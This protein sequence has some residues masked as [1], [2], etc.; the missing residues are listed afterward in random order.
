MYP[1][2]RPSKW[3]PSLLTFIAIVQL[4]NALFSLVWAGV[5]GVSL[6]MF[7]FL[8]IFVFAYFSWKWYLDEKNTHE[9]NAA[10]W[11]AEHAR[12]EA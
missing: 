11:E 9:A 8:L 7:G 4:G 3:L 6:S 10:T 2:K 5:L 1:V 12:E